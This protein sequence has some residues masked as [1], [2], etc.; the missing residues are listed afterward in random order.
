MAKRTFREKS[1]GWNRSRAADRHHDPGGRGR[2]AKRR[3]LRAGNSFERFDDRVLRGNSF[4]SSHHVAVFWAANCEGLCW[5]GGARSLLSADAGRNLSTRPGLDEYDSAILVWISPARDK[6]DRYDLKNGNSAG[7][8]DVL[9]L[10]AHAA[11]A[12]ATAPPCA[13]M[14]L[15]RHY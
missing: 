8:K 7:E 4:R 15:S 11:S 10:A 3:R 9:C 2:R 5:R 6:P 1:T 14:T 13:R 12:T